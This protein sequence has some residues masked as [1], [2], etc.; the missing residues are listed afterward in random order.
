[1]KTKRFAVLKCV[2]KSLSL[3]L[4]F[5]S[6]TYTLAHACMIQYIAIPVSPINRLRR[7][8]CGLTPADFLAFTA[9]GCAPFVMLSLISCTVIPIVYAVRQLLHMAVK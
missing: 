6:Y 9:L 7:F 5:R 3:S 4:F 8:T 2:T 1:M